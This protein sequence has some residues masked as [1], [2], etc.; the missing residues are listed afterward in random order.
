MTLRFPLAIGEWYH[1]YSRG[2]DKR[3]TFVGEKDYK[4]FIQSVYLSNSSNV[5]HRSDYNSKTHAEILSLPRSTPIVSI[6]AYALMPNHFHFLIKEIK[7]GGITKFM[8]KL[9]TSYTMYF[10]IK[11]ERIGN[12]FV[13]PFRSKHINDDRY[14]KYVTQYVH[15]NPAELFEPRWKDGVIK[16][17]NSLTLRL[18]KYPHSSFGDY[19][20]LE[21][22]EKVILDESVMTMLKDNLPSPSIIIKDAAAYYQ[23]IAL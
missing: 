17:I 23:K 10:N 7:S 15:L 3:N 16:D 19:C 5:I 21:R 6:A 22:I 13:K 8:R 18:K 20:G 1:C 9:G 11:N 4:R 2:V 14:L 12:L